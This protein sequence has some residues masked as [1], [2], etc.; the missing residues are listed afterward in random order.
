MNKTILAAGAALALTLSATAVSAAQP[1][2]TGAEACSLVT[3]MTRGPDPFSTRT[4][5]ADRAA[6][7]ALTIARAARPALCPGGKAAAADAANGSQYFGQAK[8]GAADGHG[9]RFY[10]DG[11]RYVGQWKAGAR[12]GAGV[13]I[14]PDGSRYVGSWAGDKP[15]GKGVLQYREKIQVKVVDP[16]AG[17]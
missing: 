16:A 9:A 7:Q 1:P 15:K 17:K 5:V 3:R 14:T 6:K 2:R 10:A 13:M 11:S 8:D 4:P 12:Q